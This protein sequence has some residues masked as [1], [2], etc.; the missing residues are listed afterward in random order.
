[1]F[2]HPPLTARDIGTILGSLS[3]NIQQRRAYTV[4]RM[5]KRIY[6]I[7]GLKDR[8]EMVAASK[9]QD[10]YFCDHAKKL[11]GSM[12]LFLKNATSTD[13][14]KM[15]TLLLEKGVEWETTHIPGRTGY[16]MRHFL[17]TRKGVFVVI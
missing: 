2:S 8:P 11:V 5:L 14:Q 16:K 10:Y 13:I 9:I 15:R 3:S 4:F 12:G 7:P 6:A 17:R 1:M